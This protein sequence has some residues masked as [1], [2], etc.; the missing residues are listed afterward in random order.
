MA[1]GV[2]ADAIAVEFL[3]Q[4]TFTDVLIQNVA[5]GRQGSL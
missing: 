4:L 5:Q 2:A 1:A 3:V